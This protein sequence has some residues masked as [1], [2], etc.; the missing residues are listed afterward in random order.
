MQRVVS[1]AVCLFVL[2]ITEPLPAQERI[3]DQ[4]A[5][6]VMRDQVFAATIG[7]GLIRVNLE[8]G[9]EVPLTSI[10]AQG[11]NAL[12]VT[13]KRLLGFSGQVQRWS[14]QR[15]N[16]NE[17]VL[18]RKVMPRLIM[19]RTDKR[20]FGFQG[21]AGRWKMEEFS[22]SEEFREMLAATDI[23]VVITSRRVLG[24]SAF[25]GGFFSQDLSTDEV[26][27]DTRVND[28]IV[29]LSTA[30]RRLIFRAQLGIWAEL[31]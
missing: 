15:L 8:A 29:I 19:V 10:E 13:S 21:P 23:A 30:G 31:R 5:V 11:I 6:T 3:T 2:A 16:L 7:E 12:V 18:D 14:E 27:T 26:V 22:L 20:V 24:F 4:V 9:E 25:T 17:K 1:L 28:N